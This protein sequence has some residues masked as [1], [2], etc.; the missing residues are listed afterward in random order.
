MHE[1]LSSLGNIE[2]LGDRYRAILP[3]VESDGAISIVD[4]LGPAGSGAPR[5]VHEREDET[6]VVLTGECA[7]W[8]EGETIVKGTGESVLCPSRSG[9]K[10]LRV[11]PSCS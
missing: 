9:E 4:S 6:V 1:E 8:T 10:P 7:S 11:G 2:L 3:A 5:Y